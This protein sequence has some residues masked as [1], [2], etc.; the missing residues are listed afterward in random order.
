MGCRNEAMTEEIHDLLKQISL[1][2]SHALS[3]VIEN[4]PL[5]THQM[6]IMKTI[7]KS[8]KT[9]LTSLCQ[10][11]RLSKSSLSIT[12]NRLVE[13]G[14]VSRKENAVDRRNVDIVLTAKGEEILDI[15]IKKSKEVFHRFT[16]ALSEDD[17]KDL[18]DSFMKF[19]NAIQDTM[20]SKAGVRKEK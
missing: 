20:N 12:I 8:T 2:I 5:T 19:N 18:R 6:Y 11:L 1:N 13:M 3:G 15:T 16:S 7:R 14:Y 17:L 10:D 9:N 4:S